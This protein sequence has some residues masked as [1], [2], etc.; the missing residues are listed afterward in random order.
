M[1]IR[2]IVSFIIGFLTGAKTSDK[3]KWFFRDLE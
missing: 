1:N 3:Q 2:K